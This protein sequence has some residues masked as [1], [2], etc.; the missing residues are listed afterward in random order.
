LIFKNIKTLETHMTSKIPD[1]KTK[2]KMMRYLVATLFSLLSLGLSAQTLDL[3]LSQVSPTCPA[4]TNGTATANP[5]GGV[6]PYAYAWSNGQSG[7]TTL[8]ISA[9]TY[10]VTVTDQVG[11]TAVGSIAVTEPA[12]LV[13][14]VAAAGPNCTGFSAITATA[15]G[16]TGAF[17]YTWNTGQT[18][19]TI[20]PTAPGN[21]FVTATDAQGCGIATTYYV[22]VPAQ[23]FTAYAAS[24][25]SCFG[26][27]NGSAIP[28]LVANNLPLTWAWSNGTANQ[29]LTNVASGTYSI[30]ITD[31]VGCTR[32][33]QVFVPT[34]AP[35]GVIAE[36][37]NARCF[38]T[39]SGTGKAL[40]SGGVS[41]FTY[42]W[43]NG[44]AD[45]IQQ[46]LPAGTYTVT[47]TDANGCSASATGTVT[48]PEAL[49]T[50]VVSIT[51]ACGNNGGATVQPTGGTPPYNIVWNGG[52]YT[53]TTISNVPAG[54][55]YVCTF[56]ANNCQLD[57]IVEIPGSPGL[58]VGIATEKA[59][60]PGVN[61]GEAT[62]FV[63]AGGS[64]SYNYA[65]STGQSGIAQI[66]GIAAATTVTVTVTDLVSG[67]TGTASAF[68]QAH[69][70]ISVQV[71]DTDTDCASNP[72]GTANAQAISGTAPFSYVWNVNGASVNGPSLT[73]LTAGAYAVT[74]TDAQG[75]TAVGVADIGASTSINPQFVIETVGCE[76]DS[77]TIRLVNQTGNLPNATW[78]WTLG[79]TNGSQVFGVQNPPF[80]TIPANTTL[81][82]VLEATA[83]GCA[84]TKVLQTTVT[85]APQVEIDAMAPPTLCE[86]LPTLINVA[87][88]GTYTY[89]WLNTDGL[90]FLNNNPTTVSA[91]PSA[92]TTYQLVAAN[93]ACLDTLQVP[94]QVATPV[95]VNIAN[96]TT[97]TC[98]PS[99]SVPA[100]FNVPTNGLIIKWLNAA[101]DSIA[102]GATLNVQNQIGTA[103]YT[104]VATDANGCTDSSTATIVSNAVNVNANLIA[105][106]S[107]CVGGSIAAQVVN[108]DPAD[109]LIY[110]WSV[111]ANV[112]ISDPQASNPAFVSTVG[113]T[114]TV[115]VTITNQHACSQ[116]LT[117]PITFESGGTEVSISSDAP[118]NGL[119][120]A[121]DNENNVLGTWQFGD[122]NVSNAIDPVHTYA[123]AGQYIVTFSPGESCLLPFVDT[124][125]VQAT[126][127]QAAIAVDPA[128]PCFLTAQVGFNDATQGTAPTSWAWTFQPGGQ[129]SSAQNPG[130]TFTQE[131]PVT[132]TLIVTDALG[133]RDTAVSNTLSIN[134]VNDSIVSLSTICAGADV[135]LNPNPNSNYTY[136]WTATP[137]DPTLV[138]N[139]PNPVVSPTVPTTYSVQITNGNCTVSQTAAIAVNQLN[140][141]A[142]SGDT[143]VCSMS[144]V[145]VSATAPTGSNYEWANSPAFTSV[146]ATTSAVEVMPSEVM[147]FVRITTPEG[148]TGIDSVKVGLGAVN[149]EPF[150]MQTTL[151]NQTTAELSITNNNPT[152]VLTYEWS[153]G[154][155]AVPNPTAIVTANTVF[156]A[157]VRNQNGCVDTVAFDL[158]VVNLALDIALSGPD[159]ICVGQTSLL[160]AQVNGGTA[161][162]YDWSPEAT[163]DDSSIRTP[164]ARPEEDTEYTVIVSDASGCTIVGTTKIFVM[165]TECIEPYLFVPNAFTPNGDSNNDLFR[166]RGIDIKEVYFA[167]WDRWGE[168]VYETTDPNHAGWD[169]TFRNVAST[170]DSYAWYARVTCGNGAVWEKKGNVTLLR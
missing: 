5:T 16:G 63:T 95:E 18:S 71:T 151:C 37:T 62:A 46:I 121:F 99:A 9:G 15:T 29:N 103:T 141:L 17:S 158:K 101:G 139:A 165:S 155:P 108:N 96:Q 54:T 126:T 122:G 147:N 93:G 36:M 13:L 156:T 170:P 89:T 104:V 143:L 106:A 34:Q 61:N 90:T 149:I 128:I 3:T 44:S 166:L 48:Q 133:C 150:P 157:I 118:C 132:A 114:Y 94:V 68:I 39:A 47:V 81:N 124:I 164:T 145:T 80:V 168:K 43:S 115:T 24:A 73:G 125:T 58:Q 105:N 27:A 33:D 25:P 38:G 142:A 66:N 78:A 167:V 84:G 82:V 28:N 135:A 64:G 65:W 35:V 7:Q 160:T 119:N 130:L 4:F 112:V 161:Y 87:G 67:C 129:T 75:C 20:T 56:D 45:P 169:G 148:C 30:T 97:V 76:P 60:C 138:A 98:S 162:M 50:T 14:T 134:I 85:A 31:A 41:P 137:P 11:A 92:P 53:G 74:A 159:T 70:Q 144:P 55:Y 152:D 116:T 113:G 19:A 22:P 23:I 1:Q 6:T 59:D 42:L 110:A 77:V 117:A 49:T 86:G 26:G 91:N 131:G 100:T 83:G 154:L 8:G 72:I 10:T 111:P 163:L 2:Q 102:T 51:P 32:V 127:L 52:Q 146:F 40:A 69:G 12:N 140:G 109:I 136:N 79:W 57:I 21:V 107:A 153:N 88:A 123:A 120:V